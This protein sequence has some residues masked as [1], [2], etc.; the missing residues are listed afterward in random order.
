MVHNG[1]EY[2]LMAAYAEGLNVL[3][4]ANIGS[5]A[6]AADAETAPLAAPRVLP[7]RP[8]PGGDHR[9]LAAGS[10]G[11][12]LA[13]R[14]HRPGPRRRSRTSMLRRRVSDSGEGRWTIA[15]AIDEGVPVPVLSAAL[16][17]RFTLPWPRRRRRQGAVG[18]AGR[19]RRPRRAEGIDTMTTEDD[20]PARDRTQPPADALVLFGATGDLAKRK[21]FP[22]LYHLSGAAS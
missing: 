11:R 15:A 12:Q 19:F 5:E 22:A 21:L 1:I 3:A 4:K 8:R 6:H 2:G 20:E 7:L 16:F 14:P 13:A 9:G 17:Q 10:R 18:D